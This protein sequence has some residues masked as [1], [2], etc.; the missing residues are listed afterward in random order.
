MGTD[1]FAQLTRTLTGEPNHAAAPTVADAADRIRAAELILRQYGGDD[2]LFVAGAFDT[3]L[4]HGGD[5]H[6]LLGL[7]VARG[8]STDMPHRADV[9]RRR[10][11]RVAFEF[12]RL[13]QSAPG[14][15]DTEAVRLLAL[16]FRDPARQAELRE[17]SGES[18]TFPTSRKTLR[19]IL[20][21][22]RR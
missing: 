16:A 6:K 9:K 13:R 14:M 12:E 7:H 21:E 20:H 17:E 10:D 1:A 18:A 3:W 8:R 2:A 15:T 5:L 19:L 22:L 11:Q 4:Q